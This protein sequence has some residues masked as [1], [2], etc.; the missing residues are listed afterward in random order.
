MI[1]CIYID[2]HMSIPVY[3]H[4]RYMIYEVV[5]MV[6]ICSWGHF[7]RPISRPPY[8]KRMPL[9]KRRMHRHP[10]KWAP[11]RRPLRLEPLVNVR[12]MIPKWPQD[13]A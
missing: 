4:E 9:S 8:M 6:F 7:S 1:T 3:T 5:A 10:R 2:I 13:S 12:G 11:W